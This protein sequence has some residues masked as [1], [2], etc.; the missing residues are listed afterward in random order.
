VGRNIIPPVGQDGHPPPFDEAQG[1]VGELHLQGELGH[2]HGQLQ[3]RAQVLVAED[4]AGAHG[5]AR[6]LAVDEHV[7]AVHGHLAERRGGGAVSL[8]AKIW[9]R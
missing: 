4:D 7:V 8:N 6:L 3:R 9:V 1:A 5:A 2:P